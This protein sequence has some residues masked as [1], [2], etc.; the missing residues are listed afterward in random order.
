MINGLA[1]I[2][3]IASCGRIVPTDEHLREYW[4]YKT[5]GVSKPWFIRAATGQTAFWRED[6]KV[7]P[8]A[9]SPESEVDELAV[10]SDVK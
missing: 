5:F 6:D 3:R 9:R 10:Q 8:G 2:T 4:T 1:Y 7:T